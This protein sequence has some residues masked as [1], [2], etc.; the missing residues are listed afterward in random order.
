MEEPQV[1]CPNCGHLNRTNARFCGK[2]G[3]DMHKIAA[4]PKND[5]S[6]S[7]NTLSRSTA[8]PTVPGALVHKPQ[9]SPA[10]VSGTAKVEVPSAVLEPVAPE[11]ANGAPGWL[12]LLTGLLAGILIGGGLVLR[13]PVAVGLERT[14][15]LQRELPPTPG[16]V[17]TTT[18][19]TP[20]V[21]PAV[22]P[23]TEIPSTDTEPTLSDTLVPAPAEAATLSVEEIPPADSVIL[24][25]ELSTPP[26][27]DLAPPPLSAT[28]TLSSPP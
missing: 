26:T 2:C 15:D 19:V 6:S 14:T 16:P 7:A 9:T 25:G 3:Y 8:P 12:W 5:T 1:I 22:T 17:F 27:A 23:A 4:T 10:A 28:Q 18:E 11:R 20:A 21:D 24:D 13:F